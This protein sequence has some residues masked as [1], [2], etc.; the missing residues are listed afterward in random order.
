MTDRPIVAI[1]GAAGALGSALAARLAPGARLLLLDLPRSQARLDALAAELGGIGVGHDFTSDAGWDAAHA[2]SVEAFGAAPS[3]AALIAG[4]WAGGEPVHAA[5][6][7]EV[8]RRMISLNADSVHLA[9]RRLLPPMVAA[10]RGS[11]VVVG[12]RQV[13]RP[14]MGA[15]AAAYVAGKSAAVA[16]AQAVAAEVLE[17]GVRVNAVLPSVLDTPAN[18][19]A[20]GDADPSRWVSP[21]SL[22]DVVAFLLSDA[23]RDVSGAALPVFG[24]A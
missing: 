3:G 8:W 6:D 10:G 7:D 2:R 15:G 14:W 17:H 21:A 20:M 12:A 13:E 11:V 1:T 22:A 16:L 23:A 4:G 5:A 24:R 19:A 9:L 18:R